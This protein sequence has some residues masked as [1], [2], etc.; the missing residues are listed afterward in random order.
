[1]DIGQK[2]KEKRTA[3]SLSQEDL[4]KA[5]GV[6]RQTVSSW[7]NNRS[8]PDISSILKLSDLYGA[9]LDELLKEDPVM[10]MHMENT[11]GLS[12]KYWHL[13]FDIA[14]LLL[15]IGSLAAHWGAA[16]V[17][18]ILR[19]VGLVMLPPLW[20]ARWKFFGMPK[21]AMQKCLIGL[22][23]CVA[24]PFVPELEG[25]GAIAGGIMSL[26]GLLLILNNGIF[27]EKSTRFWLI[28]AL[29]IGTPVYILF[30]GMATQLDD[31]GA[32]SQAQPFGYDYRIVEVE[33]GQAPET[34]PTL[35]LSM[36]GFSLIMDR[37]TVGNF[38]YIEPRED[39]TAKGIWQLIPED[40]SGLYKLE[41]SAQ[42]E[43]TLAYFVDDQLQ[44]RWEIAPVP[45]AQ[46]M[47]QQYGTVS[48][49][50]IDWF[51][52]G[53]FSGHPDHMNGLTLH[54]GESVSIL[55]SGGGPEILTVTA[56]YH[57]GDTVETSQIQL[58][59]NRANGYPFPEKIEKRYD[60][61]DQYI[62]Y[63]FEW[64]SGMFFF[65]TYLE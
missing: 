12:R 10:R 33:Y 41:V 5:V 2:L 51:P 7:E 60:G 64:D 65:R 4:A 11:A 59:K 23:L 55:I 52:A 50:P 26:A 58:Q 44:W 45:V 56:E 43:T 63:S 29:C 39:Q 17:G 37:E 40:A 35:E 46:L 28:I 57:N 22:A 53:S 15:P 31:Q 6:S 38:T 16:W 62:I 30:S 18:L 3:A 19:L 13:L 14:I 49:A 48:I 42:D 32:F 34:P 36:V 25:F 8:Y 47:T 20:I 9:S 21:D 24:S 61:D 1:M 27:L 54:G